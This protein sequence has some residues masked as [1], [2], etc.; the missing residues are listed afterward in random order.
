M[1]VLLPLLILEESKFVLV[2]VCLLQVVHSN[3]C[4]LR[5]ALDEERF[6]LDI[7]IA[8]VG[9]CNTSNGKELLL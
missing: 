9:S 7:A 6:T 8:L 5:K 3:V 4:G 2:G 1:I